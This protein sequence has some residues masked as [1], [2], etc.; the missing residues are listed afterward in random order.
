[1]AI[2][3]LNKGNL[4]YQLNS[5][6]NLKIDASTT[7]LEVPLKIN[8]VK[9]EEEFIPETKQSLENLN[10]YFAHQPRQEGHYVLSHMGKQMLPLSF[11][12]SRLESNL[13]SYSVKDLQS[14]FEK[15]DINNIKIWDEKNAIESN[16]NELMNGTKSLWK[17]FLLLGISFLLVEI[18]LLRFLFKR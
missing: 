16:I 11:N 5:N 4:F 13:E 15:R 7:Y 3:S 2:M 8:K 14:I 17:L 9:T 12:Y 1:M 6:Q 18:F 10:L